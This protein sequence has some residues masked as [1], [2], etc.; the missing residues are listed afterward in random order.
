MSKIEAALIAPC[1]IN[2]GVEKPKELIA[3]RRKSRD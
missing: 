2:Y 1:G 3:K